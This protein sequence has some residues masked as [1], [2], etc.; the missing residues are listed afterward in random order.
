[1]SDNNNSPRIEHIYVLYGSQTGNCEEHAHN[2]CQD[3]PTKLNP[4]LSKHNI[5]VKTKCLQLDDFLELEQ[6]QWTRL[7]II[8]VSSYGVGQAP[9]GSYRFRDLCDYWKENNTK[10]IL[11]GIQF[12]LCGLGDS[13][14]TTFFQNPTII[15]ETLIQ[16]G[17]TQIGITGKADASAPGN[18]P[19][20]QVVNEWKQQI[21]HSLANAL[22]KNNENPLLSKETLQEMQTKTIEVCT[23]INPDFSI[24]T[25]TP[26]TTT[27]NNNNSNKSSGSN[28]VMIIPVIVVAII[29]AGAFYF[30]QQQ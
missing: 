7:I 2:F 21:W 19:Q 18:N 5:E 1:M 3:V 25:T 29:A 15:R 27:E 30:L 17:A 8:F 10:N 13:S 23:K 6:A 4:L 24:T 20:L 22:I 16:V 14:Y 12:A 28:S 11:K 9:L 26:T